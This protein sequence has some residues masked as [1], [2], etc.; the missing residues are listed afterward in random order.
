MTRAFLTGISGQTGGYLAELLTERGW[1]VHGLV[2][3]RDG[4]R[5][6][7]ES[8]LPHARLHQGDLGDDAS[9]R[10]ALAA[11]DPDVVFNLGGISS[12]AQ[13]WR[14]PLLTARITGLAVASLLDACRDLQ[15]SRGR[16]IRVVQASS[17]EIFGSAPAP[18]SES[19]PITPLNPY[20]AAKAYA[21]HLVGVY[22]AS[23][24][25]A[26]TAILFNHESPRRPET[27]VTRKI[28][29]GAARIA[30]GLADSLQLGNL[31]ARRDWGWA[32][33]YADAIARI[34]EAE[35]DDFVIATGVSH[36]VQDFVAAAFRAVGID[37]WESVVSTDPGQ[38]RAADADEFVGD[39]SH[40][41]DVLGWQPTVD[42]DTMI[43]LM[44]E[45]DRHAV[46]GA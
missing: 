34:A 23:G 16:A 10:A 39:A 46:H 11:A 3:A 6:D 18:Q 41:R 22:R 30:E 33:D 37:D 17:S 20:G 9:L 36:S 8:R 45:H 31:S 38:L 26:S 44:V 4:Q 43:A 24:L 42:F 28:T 14:E 5:P 25:A 15:D 1:E 21:H 7:L 12:V 40:A 29:M 19:T 13:S 35:P 27:F 2:T 32:P